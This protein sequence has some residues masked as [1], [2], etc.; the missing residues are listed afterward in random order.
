MSWWTKKGNSKVWCENFLRNFLT[1]RR[2]LFSTHCFIIKSP[3][4][5]SC[6]GL[7]WTW[8]KQSVL[9]QVPLLQPCTFKFIDFWSLE[10]FRVA[11]PAQHSCACEAWDAVMW[12]DREKVFLTIIFSLQHLTILVWFVYFAWHLNSSNNKVRAASKWLNN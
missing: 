4:R 10:L 12:C 1:A 2:K 3:E 7:F 9:F 8:V 11:Q 5:K 6:Y